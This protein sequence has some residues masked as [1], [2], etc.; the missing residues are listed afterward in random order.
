MLMENL[1]VN[2]NVREVEVRKKKHVHDV[3]VKKK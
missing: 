2:L 3:E 1:H